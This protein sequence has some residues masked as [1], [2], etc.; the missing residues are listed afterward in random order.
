MMRKIFFISLLLLIANSVVTAQEGYQI[1]LQV[2]GMA[3]TT[4]LLGYFY[5]E[6]TY[7]KDTAHLDKQGR[8]IFSGA[9]KLSEGIYFPVVGKTRLFDFPVGKDQ[10]FKLSTKS[11]DYVANMKVEGDLENKIFF[12]DLK[13]NMA[14]NS[15]AQPYI[16]ALQDSL[17][18]P[19]AKAGARDAL[20]A[21][22]KKVKAHQQEIIDK[23]PGTILAKI[24]RANQRPDI[25]E[26]PEGKSQQDFAYKYY[27]QHYWD[28]F[29]LDDP[30]LLHLSRPIYKEKFNEYLDKLVVQ[31][32]DS[33]IKEVDH[34]ISKAKANE[35]TYKYVVWSAV[36]KY[37]YPQI[38][39]LDE[40][41]VHLFDK[42]FASGEMDYWANEQL[43][44]NLKN[45]ADQL[46]NSLIGKN[47]PNLIMLDQDLK[48]QSLYDIPNEYTVIY[49]FDPDC[50]HCKK[51]TPRLL[52]F[53]KETDYD[54]EVFAVSADTSMVKMKNYIDEMQMPWITVNGPRTYTLPYPQLYDASTTPTIYVLD[55]KKKIIAKKLPAE[56]LEEFLTRYE[57]LEKTNNP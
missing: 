39:G 55:R 10:Q 33:V 53:Y 52:Q 51:E 54:V 57:A 25:P 48:K 23:Y 19:T 17:S 2:D 1:E 24:H 38:M 37:Q 27:K 7:V 26:A 46:R 43:I 4:I 40:V 8:A 20:G 3:D 14:M 28:N 12:E 34:L 30:V 9:E 13:Y 47:A 15:Q 32:P 41:Y 42:Y 16:N 50:G 6:S 21:L 49:F 31:N 45:R 36:I 29:E 5:G 22:D 35:E 44:D 11:P 56:R 18:S